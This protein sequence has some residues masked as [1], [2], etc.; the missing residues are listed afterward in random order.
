VRA[1]TSDDAGDDEGIVSHPQSRPCL[2]EVM[3]RPEQHLP[4]PEALDYPGPV[5][6]QLICEQVLQP[7]HRSRQHAH[8]RHRSRT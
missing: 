7:F 4:R 2:P 5:P 3:P 8:L 1:D 6:G